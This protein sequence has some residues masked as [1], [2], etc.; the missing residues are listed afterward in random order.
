[1]EVFLLKLRILLLSIVTSL[2]LTIPSNAV[3]MRS[4]FS[5]VTLT[6]SDG[7]ANCGGTVYADSDSDKISAEMTLW[8]GG[9]CVTRWEDEAKGMLL[10]SETVDVVCGQSYTLKVSATVNGVSI[11]TASKTKTCS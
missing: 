11:P 3:Q 1:M 2:V 4:P 6:F 9:I 7:A 5:V 8:S 10:F